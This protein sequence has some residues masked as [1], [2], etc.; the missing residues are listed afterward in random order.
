MVGTGIATA[1]ADMVNQEIA[2][3][4]NVNYG[5]SLYN[6]VT[7]MFTFGIFQAY[8]MGYG[9]GRYYDPKPTG[10]NGK[11]T[12]KKPSNDTKVTRTETKSSTTVKASEATDA[13]DDYLGTNTHDINPVTGTSDSNRIFPSDSTRSI[14]FGSHEMD[15]M[16][17]TKFHFHY[18]SWFY[19][20]YGDTMHIKNL[21]KRIR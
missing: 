15:S 18:E 6:G 3:E 20:P 7:N 9:T 17:T 10:P 1:A 12:V 21:L 4:G 14:R 13:W 5:Q 11:V 8:S 19:D 2:N 16:G